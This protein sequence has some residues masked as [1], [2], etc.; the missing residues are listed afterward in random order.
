MYE[1]LLRYLTVVSRDNGVEFTV[2][3]RRDVLMQLLSGSDYEL[4]SQTP[5]S[6]V[7]ARK[8]SLIHI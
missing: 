2:A 1:E 6:L 3:D 4:V 7:Y 8:L 5:L